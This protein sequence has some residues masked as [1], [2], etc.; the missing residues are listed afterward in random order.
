MLQIFL[1]LHYLLVSYSWDLSIDGP[2]C[3]K[4]ICNRVYVA[5]CESVKAALV[6]IAYA[7]SESSNKPV[8]HCTFSS[9]PS[10][11]SHS[12]NGRR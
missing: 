4:N 7:S 8:H 10:L 3:I 1:G 9:E 12:M 11:L 5:L 6:L 2:F